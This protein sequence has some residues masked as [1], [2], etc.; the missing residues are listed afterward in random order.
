MKKKINVAC[1][2]L[3]YLTLLAQ[4][5]YVI[6]GNVAHEILG[7]VFFVSMVVHLFIKKYYYGPAFDCCLHL[8]DKQYGGVQN[9]V[10]MV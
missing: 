3:M 7:I 2:L 8:D 10:P 6:V 1:E 5:L 9:P 4:M